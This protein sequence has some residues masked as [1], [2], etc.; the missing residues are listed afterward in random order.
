MKGQERLYRSTSSLELKLKQESGN[1]TLRVN[2]ASLDQFTQEHAGR[3][4]IQPVSLPL[5]FHILNK[6]SGEPLVSYSD[7]ELQLNALNRDFNKEDYSERHPADT[8]EG[9]SAVAADMEIQFCLAKLSGD[10]ANQDPVHYV[11]TP[12]NSWPVDHSVQLPD[13]GGVAP[14]EPEHYINVW[15]VDLEDG[16]SGFAQFP[17]GPS[18]T[19]GIVI[20]YRFFGIGGDTYSEYN[21]GK[22]LT[23]LMGNYLNLFPLW[24]KGRKCSDDGVGDTPIHNAPNIGCPSYK[25]VTVC[26]GYQVEMSMNFMDNTD[27]ACM[28]MFTEGQKQRVHTLFISGGA[29][30]S[31]LSTGTT[32]CNTSSH[33]TF[34][35]PSSLSDGGAEMEVFPNPARTTLYLRLT[36]INGGRLTVNVSSS[37]G[38]QVYHERMSLQQGNQEFQIPCHN[39][40]PGVYFIQA[41]FPEGTLT[42]S[43]TVQ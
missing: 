14:W 39:W 36:S 20:D 33:F 23:H 1:P 7:V 35:D 24:G 13:S 38:Q 26:S 12:R 17:G 25:H 37:I 43:I 30:E 18:A 3:I 32:A 2:R 29:R 8:R 9:F 10:L 28:Y 27:D 41:S 16:G 5:V 6:Q 11:N 31:L 42:E 21:Q 15:V 19:D 22:T 4:D 34:T 40:A